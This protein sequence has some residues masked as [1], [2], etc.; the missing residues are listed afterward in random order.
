VIYDPAK[1][2]YYHIYGVFTEE[3]PYP[4]DD[5]AVG[6]Y[7]LV[8]KGKCRSVT[9]TGKCTGTIASCILRRIFEKHTFLHFEVLNSAHSHIVRYL[10]NYTN[11]IHNIYSLRVFTV[12][13]LHF[14]V[15][16]S[17]RLQ[18]DVTQTV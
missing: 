1:C 2:V 18:S 5:T 3:I 14:A 16:G 17:L 4:L 7:R 10:F 6:E 11:K 15:F 13:L 9:C 8:C 12:F